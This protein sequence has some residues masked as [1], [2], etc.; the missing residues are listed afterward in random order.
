MKPAIILLAL[1][2]VPAALLPACQEPKAAAQKKAV[3]LTE[4]EREMLKDREV[5]ENLEL[6]Q[7]LDKIQYLGL[8]AEPDPEKEDGPAVPGPKKTEREK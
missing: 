6:L 3:P 4:E 8:F 1:M 7:S 2:S 5:L